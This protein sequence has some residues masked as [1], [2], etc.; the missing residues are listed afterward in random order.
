MLYL[1]V[2]KYCWIAEHLQAYMYSGDQFRV[3]YTQ[4]AGAWRINISAQVT[5]LVTTSITPRGPFHSSCFFRI[6]LLIGWTFRF[7]NLSPRFYARHVNVVKCTQFMFRYGAGR[8]YPYLQ[9]LSSIVLV[10]SWDCSGTSG[11]RGVN[12]SLGFPRMDYTIPIKKITKNN[13]NNKK[14]AY[15]NGYILVLTDVQKTVM[16]FRLH[17]VHDK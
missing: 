4:C 15:F 3:S 16:G 8:F 5:R 9:G 1:L 2:V 10:L 12:L 14:S 11:R 17:E 13:N 6:V 7:Y